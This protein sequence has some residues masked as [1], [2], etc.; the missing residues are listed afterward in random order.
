MSGFTIKNSKV[1]AIPQNILPFFFFFLLFAFSAGLDQNCSPCQ[2]NARREPDTCGM[3]MNCMGI[4]YFIVSTA[5]VLRHPDLSN[6][7]VDPS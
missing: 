2:S 5:L 6:A 3:L 4:F 7:I 1:L